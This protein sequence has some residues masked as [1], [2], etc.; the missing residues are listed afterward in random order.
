MQQESYHFPWL[1]TNKTST[2]QGVGLVIVA[3]DLG[4]YVF[5]GLNFETSQV[6]PLLRD[7]SIRDFDPILIKGPI[8][9]RC[10]W[11]SIISWDAGKMTWTPWVMKTKNK[12]KNDHYQF[13]NKERMAS[14]QGNLPNSRNIPISIHY[15][16][17]KDFSNFTTD[18]KATNLDSTE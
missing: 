18:K 4:I 3:W 10:D 8:S 13:P 2:T 1:L 16:Y 6:Y 9:G 12:N 5:L 11:S 7:Q 14:F 17:T 15:W